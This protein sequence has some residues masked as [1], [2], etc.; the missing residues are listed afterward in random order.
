M[1]TEK[2]FDNRGRKVRKKS[3]RVQREL[4]IFFLFFVFFY[5]K[6]IRLTFFYSFYLA[7]GILEPNN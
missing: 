1:N 2:S 5:F 7:L 4:A 3:R 6:P